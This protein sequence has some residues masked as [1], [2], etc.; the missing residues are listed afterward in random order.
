MFGTGCPAR[1]LGW[2]HEE[3]FRAAGASA[4][5]AANKGRRRYNMRRLPSDADCNPPPPPRQVDPEEAAVLGKPWT[6]R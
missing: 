4:R 6:R 2:G 1:A 3:G 5:K